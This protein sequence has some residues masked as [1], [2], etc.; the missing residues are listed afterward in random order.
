MRPNTLATSPPTVGWGSDGC[1]VVPGGTPVDEINDRLHLE[2]AEDDEYDSIGGFVLHELGRVP[3][4]G[5]SVE[6]DGALLTVEK[7]AGNRIEKVRIE[8][9]VVE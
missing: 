8:R 4:D 9:R 3:E 7:M 5:E 1:A 6:A 2:L